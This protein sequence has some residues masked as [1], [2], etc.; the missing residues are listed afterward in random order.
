MGA[1]KEGK[2]SDQ[3]LLMRAGHLK[4][5]ASKE[6]PW[7]EKVQTKEEVGVGP[8]VTPTSDPGLWAALGYEKHIYVTFSVTTRTRTHL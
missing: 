5:L 4:G 6:C 8:R 1:L 7:K 3:A 2:L